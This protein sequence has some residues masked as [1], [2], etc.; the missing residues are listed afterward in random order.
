MNHLNYF[1]PYHSKNVGHEDNLTRAFLVVLRHS[2]SA[3]MLFYDQAIKS[4]IS[5]RLKKGKTFSLPFFSEL[6]YKNLTYHTQKSDVSEIIGSS[7]LSILITDE[8]FEV[9]KEIEL[10]TRGARYD[11]I[12]SFG[13]QLSLIL[14]NKPKSYN[15][16]EEQ[17]SPNLKKLSK[18]ITL[19]PVPAIITWKDI[20]KNFN[21][22]ISS[23]QVSGSERIMISDFLDFVDHNFPYLN[24]YDSLV[25]CKKDSYL[26]DRRIKNIF[27]E[28]ALDEDHIDYHRGWRSYYFKTG[29][30]EIWMV[31]MEKIFDND[32]DYELRISLYYADVISQARSYYMNKIPF[33]KVVELKSKEWGFFPNFHISHINA[34]LIWFKTKEK[35]EKKY[36]DYWIENYHNLKQMKEKE[37]LKFINSLKKDELIIIDY[38]KNQ[39]IQDKVINANRNKFNPCPGFCLYYP[40]DSNTAEKLDSENKF[41]DYL[42]EKIIEGLSILNKEILFFK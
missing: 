39:E 17:L 4:C 5:I 8:H 21:S 42:K 25:Q 7:V 11:G 35:N 33:S 38:E 16:W 12:I 27:K 37:L 24:P 32:G 30:D 28:L 6:D 18:N 41:I 23:E 40:I 9:Q 14:E 1:E 36:Y 20:I 3:L 22:L 26:I 34:G 13:D 29:F 15:V 31:G 19:I 2:I 10:S